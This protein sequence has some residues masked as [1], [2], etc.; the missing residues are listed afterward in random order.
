M[1][2]TLLDVKRALSA[3]SWPL[4][5]AGA[6]G[7]A[8]AYVA[9]QAR[10]LTGQSVVLLAES[11]QRATR[12][13][14]D[15]QALD[16]E[17]TVALLNAPD[18]SPYDHLRP[19]PRG[20]L[21]R[22]AALSRIDSHRWDYLV[23]SP[24]A[25]LRKFVPRSVFLAAT[26]TVARKQQLDMDRLALG[27][28]EAGYQ[29]TPVCEDPGTFAV[30]GAI[31]DVWAPASSKPSRI[32]MSF[33]RVE[34]IRYFDPHSQRTQDDHQ[35]SL[36][37]GP[38]REAVTTESEIAKVLRA[39]QQLF[40]EVSLP[41]TQARDLLQRAR[42]GRL[43]MET[44]QLLPAYGPLSPLSARIA[45]STP[46][47]ISRPEAVV[48][49][50]EEERDGALIAHQRREGRL[51]YPIDAHYLSDDELNQS[52]AHF[53]VTLVHASAVIGPELDGFAGITN[54][55]ASTPRLNIESQQRLSQ[56]LRESREES[57]RAEGLAP[58]VAQIEHWKHEGYG[59]VLSCG[60]ASGAQRLAAL[61]APHDLSPLLSE[62]AS[63]WADS[64]ELRIIESTLSQG[65]VA[66]AEQ[67]VLLT[68]DE[69]FGRTR[70]RVKQTPARALSDALSDL[71]SLAVG[72]W[73]VHNEHGVGRYLGL[74][75]KTV[76]GC[77]VDLLAVEYA[78]GDRLLLPVYRL[79]QIQK[80][81]GQGNPKLD[82][83]GGLTFAKTRKK[84]RKQARD[85]A[86]QL[87]RLY[88][89]RRASAR[90]P[91][92]A[93]GADYAA[94]EAA[95]PH[96]ETPDQQA[97]IEDVLAD[98]QKET[99]M[100]RLICGD[101]GFGK[102]EVAL[103]ATFLSA[104]AGRQVALLCPT[105]VLA[106][107]H[108]RTFESRLTD[109]GLRVG[110]L[111]R[112]V[113]PKA[114]KQVLSGLKDGSTDV[115]VGTHR[116]LS[117]DVHF[118]KLGLL[119][120]DEEQRFGVTHKERIK[121]LRKHVDVL[122]LTATPIPRT[123]SLAVGG[124]R[125]MSV[126]QTPPQQRRAIATYTARFEP[127]LIK[128]VIERELAR[129]GQVYYVHNRVEGIY[130]RAAI[131][132]QLCPQARIAIGHGQMSER[133]LESTMLAFV[134]GE[135]DVL[136]ATAIIESG[137]DIPRANT[138]IID[139]ADLFGLAQLYQL[140]GRVGRASQRAFCYLLVPPLGQLSEEAQQRIETLER[141]TELG[142]GFQIAT[143]DLEMRGA[144]ELL[145]AD[146][147]GTVASVGFELFA[148][149]LEQ[150][151]AELQGQPYAP[152]VDP[153][154][155]VDAEALIPES[156]VEDIGLRLNLYKR[157]ASAR[158]NDEVTELAREMEERF[159]RP[160]DVVLRFC[161]V[162]QLKT[163]LRSLRALSLHATGKSVAIDLANDTPLSISGL[164]AMIKQSSSKYT[165]S[166]QG[167]LKRVAV[168]PEVDG[169]AHA[170]R[171]L[172][173][174]AELGALPQPSPG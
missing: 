146:Q 138:M 87:L 115:V 160:P 139:R 103:R 74:D 50:I 21:S 59:V 47:V 34:S 93:P 30:R 150:A 5:L 55:P 151:S 71:R 57:G 120:V 162:M 174:L 46:L 89:E 85:L 134:E 23:T 173:E 101:V 97:A 124:M 119:I 114:Q 38:A 137:L 135:V 170:H 61:L 7:C 13:H 22:L 86:D 116:L 158:Q 80:F 20:E 133:E 1:S 43:L 168:P 92:E 108:R 128:E 69:I 25:W 70:R 157:F 8:A 58:L 83:L 172:S 51:H 112:F 17:A 143:M 24:G 88:A 62:N 98:L 33:D 125:D 84:A 109:S 126:I 56:R 49:A 155:T 78:A 42:S 136:L 104:Y 14:D 73:V 11:P 164:L 99:V 10:R 36:L 68:E 67:L 45:A 111:S 27:L 18:H 31:I 131:I 145:G 40:D 102:T 35:N 169:L 29:R 76:D 100:D 53:R 147:S 106:E 110:A 72:D 37:L 75:R 44:A 166:P 167:R 65:M 82:R 6:D 39:L 153:E 171:A 90:P 140:R 163:R 122:T 91:L 107:Q 94:F 3:A 129:G 152:D 127:A 41:T 54:A 132:R 142:S 79:N 9:C 81:S 165:L 63:G 95:F 26:T 121:E 149:M 154:I 64:G 4:H 156:Y 144:G 48:S 130:E 141:Y 159:G 12:F 96:E 117:K 123:L 28:T 77:A 52:L 19:D 16:P 148:Q 60:S 113:K 161:E 15:L 2:E 66:P 118:R 105:T 32:E